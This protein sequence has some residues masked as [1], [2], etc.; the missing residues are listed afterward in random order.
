MRHSNMLIVLS[1]IGWL[2]LVPA[3]RPAPRA[4]HVAPADSASRARALHLLNRLTYGPRPGDVDRVA[5][6]GVDRFIDQQ[7][8]PDQIADQELARRLRRF[9]ILETSPRELA[10]VFAQALRDRR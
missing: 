4:E 5:A 2:A 8:R 3:V 9:K 10:R 1:G 7:L 6:M